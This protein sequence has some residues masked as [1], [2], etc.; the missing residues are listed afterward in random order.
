[1]RSLGIL[2]VVLLASACNGDTT[3]V[4]VPFEDGTPTT[5]GT[6]VGRALIIR[7]TVTATPGQSVAGTTVRVSAV[8]VD[9]QGACAGTTT[10]VDRTT[11]VSG[12]F[13]AEVRVAREVTDLCVTVTATPPAGSPLR[14]A[15]VNV[16]RVSPALETTPPTPLPERVVNVSLTT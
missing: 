1:M 11:T 8:G 5:P 6:G 4:A 3:G 10:N 13:R 15:T 14:V 7:G 2:A 16:G 9:A 12:E